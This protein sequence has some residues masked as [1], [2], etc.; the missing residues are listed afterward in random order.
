MKQFIIAVAMSCVTA[1]AMAEWTSLS[2]IGYPDTYYIDKSSVR[3]D[4]NLRKAWIIKDFHF[5]D[6]VGNN[7]E[8]S[9]RYKQEFDCKEERIRVLFLTSHSRRMAKGKLLKTINQPTTWTEV[10]PETVEREVL[11][12]VCAL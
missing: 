11:N 10:P 8:Q 3:K 1:S 5:F 2:D 7:G 6:D 9:N 4:G 12:V